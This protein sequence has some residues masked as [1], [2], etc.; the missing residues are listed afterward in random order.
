MLLL[1][2]WSVDLQ[3]W[4]PPRVDWK[5]RHLSLALELKNVNPHY[6]LIVRESLCA[7]LFEKYFLR[8]GFQLCLSLDCFCVSVI[9][10]S[11]LQLLSARQVGQLYTQKGP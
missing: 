9:R 11:Y 5:C 1:T 4:Q 10:N 6:T 2:V 8:A 3:Q 7:S